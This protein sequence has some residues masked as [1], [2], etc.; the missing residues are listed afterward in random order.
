MNFL[1]IDVDYTENIAFVAGV[2]FSSNDDEYHSFKSQVSPIADYVSGQFYNRELPCIL[3]LLEEHS[4]KPD[5]IIVDGFV[6]LDEHKPG[7]GKYLYDA[8]SEKVKVIGVAKNPRGEIPDEFK[9]YRGESKKPLYVTCEG[10]DLADA[11]RVIER[12]QGD[13]RIPTMLKM[14]DSLCRERSW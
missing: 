13:F 5:C 9:V 12:L 8:L 6:Y 2:L 4:L 1:A 11:C 10:L 14:A 7:L 3:K